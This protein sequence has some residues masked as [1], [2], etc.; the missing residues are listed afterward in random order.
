MQQRP[1]CCLATLS[2]YLRPS[3]DPLLPLL[4]SSSLGTSLIPDPHSRFRDLVIGCQAS[5]C[6]Q[7]DFLCTASPGSLVFVLY[8]QIIFLCSLKSDLYLQIA[9]FLITWSSSALVSPDY[10]TPSE[11]CSIC[12]PHGFPHIAMVKGYEREKVLMDQTQAMEV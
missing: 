9:L 10:N 2:L 1:S 11:P 5:R 12:H 3:L 4:P 7:P 8:C 6:Y